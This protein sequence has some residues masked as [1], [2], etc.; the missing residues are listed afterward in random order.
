M[1]VIARLTIESMREAGL[2]PLP[3]YEARL[4]ATTDEYP[5]TFGLASYGTRFRE[6]S[7]DP[8]WFVD[9]LASNA[10]K[11]AEGA[12]RIWEMIG[13]TGDQAI[14]RLL[15]RHCMDEARH[16]KFYIAMIGLA[17]PDRLSESAR[18]KLL[19]DV[20][21]FTDA[22]VVDAQAKK[23]P[24]EGILDELIQMNAGEIRTRIHQLLLRP[25]I[26]A[27]CPE[28]NQ[29][30]LTKLLDSILSDETSHVRYTSELIE[31]AIKQGEGDWV[32]K[33]M[34]K[35]WNQFNDITATELAEDVFE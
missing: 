12:R 28:Q 31:E 17:F 20:P 9:S 11:E 1:N 2:P 3:E 8:K 32:T 4:K 6:L 14:C 7:T 21:V 15:R 34:R 5:P 24:P 22:M 25:V 10:A 27:W 18:A 23:T 29:G 16:A 33:I 26:L 35:R 30:G 13:R 19:S